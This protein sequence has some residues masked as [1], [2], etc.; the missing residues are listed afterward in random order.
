[1]DER[2]QRAACAASWP[3]HADRGRGNSGSGL[4]RH[5]QAK[6]R[7]DRSTAGDDRGARDG[8]HQ[9]A[10][11]DQGT[12]AADMATTGTEA[13]TTEA[14]TGGRAG[15]FT[16]A[17]NTQIVGSELDPAHSGSEEAIALINMYEGLTR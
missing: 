12:S 16:Y 2:H 4:R 14:A 6:R 9:A 10:P 17:D 11:T 3:V 8:R 7:L 15:T 13:A 1:M 5:R